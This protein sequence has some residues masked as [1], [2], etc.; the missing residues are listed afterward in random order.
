[1]RNLI[2]FF[3]KFRIFLFF[4]FLQGIALS[5][6]FSYLQF[7][8]SQ[9]LTSA[10]NISGTVYKIENDVTKHF[11]LSYN[12]SKL[13]RENI[14]LREKLPESFMKLENGLFKIDDTTYK[15]QYAYT[16]AEVINSTVTKAN[17]YFTI[18]IG[19]AQGVK[20]KQGVFSDKG[21]V[22]VVHFTSKHYSIVKSVLT[23]NINVDVL[24]VNKGLFG[25]L[26]W[27]GK[28]ARY[29]SI[30]GISND[31]RIKKWTK[32][33]TR[34]GS[35]I[36]PKGIPVGKIVSLSSVEGKPVWDVKI[37]FSEDYRSLQRVYVVKN[38]LLNE[39]QALEARIPLDEND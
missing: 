23:T 38:L 32:V 29:G 14:R 17:N 31:I 33:V 30:T 27:D 13:Q 12:N 8:R 5:L 20:R 9:Y 11:N 18:N 34:G 15:Q 22:G 37:R 25:L 7:P 10:N 19:S 21:V 28:D 2:A 16:P 35:G 24:I 3:Q 26:K 4:A 6:Y 36:F 39:Q 1:M